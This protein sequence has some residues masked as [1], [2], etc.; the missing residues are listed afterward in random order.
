ME[1][2]GREVGRRHPGAGRSHRAGYLKRGM[3][4]PIGKTIRDARIARGLNQKVL[5]DLAGVAPRTLSSVESGQ[6]GMGITVD[7][8]VR[9]SDA[10]ELDAGDVLNGAI[11]KQSNAAPVARERRQLRREAVV[12]ERMQRL[13][14]RWGTVV[15]RVWFPWV[16]ASYGPYRPEHIVSHF[17]PQEPSYPDAVE[18]SFR[19]VRRTSRRGRPGVR[20]SRTTQM[21][22][23]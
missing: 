20:R 9:L 23:S 6:A 8:L 7:T 22:G 16:V 13:S 11:G 10:L 18:E 21:L 12:R 17:D 15:G 1:L 14:T 19:L 5:A 4:R 2:D 3:E